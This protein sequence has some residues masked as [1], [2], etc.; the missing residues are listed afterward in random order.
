MLSE[1][2]FDLI[3]PQLF[4]IRFVDVAVIEDDS[5][6]EDK[7]DLTAVLGIPIYSPG[8]RNLL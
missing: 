5:K 3:N 1:I 8:S 7:K 4:K 2:S 6:I